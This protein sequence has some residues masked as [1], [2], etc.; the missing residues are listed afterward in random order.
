M[1][2]YLM[3]ICTFA[4]FAGTPALAQQSTAPGQTTQDKDTATGAKAA[5][6]PGQDIQ[7]KGTAKGTT[8]GPGVTTG[9]G[10][11][12]GSRHTGSDTPR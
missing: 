2:R 3:I 8:P 7:D 1:I 4:A 6:V 9:S 5:S 12:A 10:S 11:G